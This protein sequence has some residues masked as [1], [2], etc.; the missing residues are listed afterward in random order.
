MPRTFSRASARHTLC[1]L[2][3]LIVAG[4]SSNPD[5]ELVPEQ[6]ARIASAEAPVK[7][8]DCAE[9][10]RRSAAKADFYV[11]RL[12]SPKSMVPPP[13]STRSMPEAVRAVRY[14]AV[15]ITVL[16]DTMGRADMKTFVVVKSTHPWLAQSVKSAVG[17]WSFEPAEL[18]GCKVPRR[19]EWSATS[20]RAPKGEA[21]GR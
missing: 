1:T 12:P 9:A 21:A 7:P 11:D 13:I 3:I 20:G 6:P 15:K 16:V 4:C 14:N 17:K 8:G 10:L 5:P 2:S 19:F 18:A